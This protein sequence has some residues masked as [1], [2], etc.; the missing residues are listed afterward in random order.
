M[1]VV[2]AALVLGGGALV[3]RGGGTPA[4][5]LPGACE[6]RRTVHVASTRD[7][8]IPEELHVHRYDAAGRE[9]LEQRSWATHAG[10]SVRWTYDE[11]GNRVEEE[12]FTPGPI[13]QQD[14]DG[15]KRVLEHQITRLRWTYDDAGRMLTRE[16]ERD[17]D[18]VVQHTTRYAYDASGRQVSAHAEWEGKYASDTVFEYDAQGRRVVER[19]DGGAEAVRRYEHDEHGRVVREIED[20]LADGT[21]DRTLTRVFDEHGRV[22]LETIDERGIGV[23]EIHFTYDDAGNVLTRR[24]RQPD[25]EVEVLDTYRYDCWALRD[26]LAVDERGAPP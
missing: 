15:T 25:G 18:G 6:V 19:S 12:R 21:D 11:A 14:A 20:Y 13:H 2:T 5:K 9:V 1:A 17:G 8:G 16:L 7:S 23:Q 3:L 22:T 10:D 24:E 4:V 26:G